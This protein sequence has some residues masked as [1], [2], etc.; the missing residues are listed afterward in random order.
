[1]AVSLVRILRQYPNASVLLMLALL[2]P[3]SIARPPPFP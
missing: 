1:M 3:H 2:T